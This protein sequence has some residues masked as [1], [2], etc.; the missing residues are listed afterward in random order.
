MSCVQN[1]VLLK[2]EGTIDDNKCVILVEGQLYIEEPSTVGDNCDL[3]RHVL[4]KPRHDA[5]ATCGD[6]E[7]SDWPTQ[8]PH[9]AGRVVH[10]LGCKAKSQMRTNTCTGIFQ[11]SCVDPSY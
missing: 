10:S 5:P 2:R 3:S 6:A 1:K 7:G 9:G 11:E 8:S 4:I